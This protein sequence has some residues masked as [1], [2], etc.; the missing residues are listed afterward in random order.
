M[1]RSWLWTLVA[2]LAIA[3]LSYTAFVILRPPAMPPGFQYGSGHI[4]GT[5]VKF[6]PEVGGRILQQPLA[7]GSR[8]TRG[9]RLM[10]VDPKLGRDT[11]AM[12][13]ATEPAALPH[14]D[15]AGRVPQGQR[16]ARVVAA[17]RGTARDRQHAVRPGRGDVSAAPAMKALTPACLF[18]QE[19]CRGESPRGHGGISA[20]SAFVVGSDE[21]GKLATVPRA[22]DL[23]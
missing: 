9:Q 1:K 10:V 8:A 13:V 7:E 18:L 11:A 23:S 22:G 15:P 14:G 20:I 19:H 12:A 16:L 5:Q 4:E 6:A 21:E 3:A 17:S 2:V